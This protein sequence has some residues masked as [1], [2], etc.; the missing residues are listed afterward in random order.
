MVKCV[1]RLSI[2]L[3]GCSFTMAAQNLVKNPSFEASNTRPTAMVNNTK[4]L[5]Y[6][7]RSSSKMDHLTAKELA[8]RPKAPATASKFGKGY[9]GFC[10]NAPNNYRE[11]LHGELTHPLEE[12]K[13]YKISFYI[14]LAEDSKWAIRDIGTL[15][16]EKNGKKES[17]SALDQFDDIKYNEAYNFTEVRHWL[18]YGNKSAW[19]QVSTTITA[20][21]NE[22]NFTIGNFRDDL[23][24][25]V[26]PTT[27]SINAAY[28]YLDMVSVVE[29]REDYV[30][31]DAKAKKPYVLEDVIFDTG[32]Y[33]LDEGARKEMDLLYE[34]LKKDP[35]LF[36]TINAHPDEKGSESKNEALSV[37]RARSVAIY[38][39]NLGLP[40]DRIRWTG[41]E[42]RSSLVENLMRHKRRTIGRAEFKVSNSAFESGSSMAETLFEEDN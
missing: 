36:V 9:T 14:R 4:D 17:E 12:G 38:L 8:N 42:S 19:T 13:Q 22:T 29:L 28:Y 15:F 11:F 25:Q 31:H 27:G 40:Q 6:W 20:K 7:S 3:L 37:K 24:S 1:I 39:A 23:H 18:Y 10:L 34:E 35:S 21:G 30:H 5:P 32:E 33:V 2:F 16:W 26:A 41:K